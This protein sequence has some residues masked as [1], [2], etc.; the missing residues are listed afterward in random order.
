MNKTWIGAIAVAV[1]LVIGLV[2]F[3]GP[4]GTAPEAALPADGEPATESA[5]EAIEP[6]AEGAEGGAETNI[7]N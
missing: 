7:A 2:V 3:S 4:D 6:A 1:I 5:A